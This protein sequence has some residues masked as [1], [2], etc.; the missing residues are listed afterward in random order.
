MSIEAIWIVGAVCN[1]DLL[2]LTYTED[3]PPL[4]KFELT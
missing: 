4:T 1:R 2:G 3:L